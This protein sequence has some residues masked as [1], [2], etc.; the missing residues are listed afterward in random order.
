MWARLRK[1]LDAITDGLPRSLSATDVRGFA[2]A[3]RSHIAAEEMALDDLFTRWIDD[4][5][6]AALGRA[7]RDR[8]AAGGIGGRT[9]S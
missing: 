3:Y 9:A 6:R 2:D 8:R 5:D 1:P 7:M 4:R